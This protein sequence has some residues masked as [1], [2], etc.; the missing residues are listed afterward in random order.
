MEPGSQENSWPT[1]R[2][3]LASN[4][5]F[6]IILNIIELGKGTGRGDSKRC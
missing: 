4:F 5:G 2:V 3:A 1:S 6:D